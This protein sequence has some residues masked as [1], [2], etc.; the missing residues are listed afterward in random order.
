MNAILR[1]IKEK[2]GIPM[3]KEDISSDSNKVLEPSAIFV[4]IPKD[5]GSEDY[6][7]YNFQPPYSPVPDPETRPQQPTHRQTPSVIRDPVLDTTRVTRELPV[8][9][10]ISSASFP[11]T[12]L[13]IVRETPVPPPPPEALEPSIF[14]DVQ[15]PRTENRRG[16]AAVIVGAAALVTF[17]SIFGVRTLFGSNEQSTQTNTRQITVGSEKP[18]IPNGSTVPTETK[19]EPS[20]NGAVVAPLPTATT[21]P[22]SVTGTPKPATSTN[23]APKIPG[24]IIIA[25]PTHKA[26]SKTKTKPA[27]TQRPTAESTSPPVAT[28]PVEQS[29]TLTTQIPTT[30]QEWTPTPTNTPEQPALQQMQDTL[31]GV[32]DHDFIQNNPEVQGSLGHDV[33]AQSVNGISANDVQ[34]YQT[35]AAEVFGSSEYISDA[36]PTLTQSSLDG[37]DT[38][39]AAN[40]LLEGHDKA[41]NKAA[42]SNSFPA[43]YQK[44]KILYSGD[45]TQAAENED[46]DLLN[47]TS[48]GDLSAQNTR[49]LDVQNVSTGGNKSILA[50]LYTE[51]NGQPMVSQVVMLQGPNG[52]V[53]VLVNRS[54]VSTGAVATPETT[55]TT[56]VA[57][58]ETDTPSPTSTE[59]DGSNGGNNH[60]GIGH[61][62]LFK[63]FGHL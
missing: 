20:L 28:A 40:A 54:Q 44:S 61:G 52:I 26:S 24:N 37:L 1:L 38:Q 7:L 16:R 51:Y 53:A 27:P 10:Q 5:G 17:V 14:E 6:D 49:V 13:E 34:N 35:N 36:Q 19:G 58:T 11:G 50:T 18:T 29:P 33:A 60:G 3:G 46:M 57:P 42:D 25:A 9:R 12:A 45:L 39:D 41:L 43:K 21:V 56:Q 31:S 47:S 48:G 59:N 63:L 62:W 2:C 4:P 23:A 22:K 55:P 30:T 15:N 32:V 8:R